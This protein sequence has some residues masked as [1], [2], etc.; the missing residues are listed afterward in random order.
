MYLL[1]SGLLTLTYLHT[2]A[3]IC[4]QRELNMYAFYWLV[5]RRWAWVCTC[6]FYE[7]SEFT[8]ICWVVWRVERVFVCVH[9]HMT[10]ARHLSSYIGRY[11]QHSMFQH[12]SARIDSWGSIFMCYSGWRAGHVSACAARIKSWVSLYPVSMLRVSAASVC[13]PAC[14]RLYWGMCRI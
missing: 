4:T 7:S 13:Y 3:G 11:W 1:L 9:V 6:G 5:S 8:C 2:M 12:V 10:R 14:V